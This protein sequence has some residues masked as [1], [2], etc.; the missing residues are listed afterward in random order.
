MVD[1]HNQNQYNV[2]VI[3]INN[4]VTCKTPQGFCNNVTFYKLAF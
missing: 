4:V 3:C 2:R 1:K